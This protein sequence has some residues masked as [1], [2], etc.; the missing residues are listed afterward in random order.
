[1]PGISRWGFWVQQLIYKIL[2][3]VSQEEHFFYK[4]SFL[5][6][7]WVFAW[8]CEP[9][10]YKWNLFATYRLLWGQDLDW[11]TEAALLC[12][13]CEVWVVFFCSSH[14]VV[15]FI[16]LNCSAVYFDFVPFYYLISILCSIMKMGGKHNKS[17]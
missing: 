17:V 12:L 6:M 5:S 10:I 13:R 8:K 9:S 14:S 2:M 4:I 16:L 15:K 1:M 11:I 7:I 3:K